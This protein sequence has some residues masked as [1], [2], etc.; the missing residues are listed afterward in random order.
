[1]KSVKIFLDQC[2]DTHEISKAGRLCNTSAVISALFVFPQNPNLNS[3]TEIF[4]EKTY[5]VKPSYIEAAKKFLDS[6]SRSLDFKTAF[7][8]AEKL[9][10]D[11]VSTQTK[12]KINNLIP[13][14]K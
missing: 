11:W 8:E 6:E 9:I 5:K 4:M 7:A 13:A 1:M 10:N 2:L 12:Q 3:A 14:G